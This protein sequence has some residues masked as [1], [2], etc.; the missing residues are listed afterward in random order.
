MA[1]EKPKSRL[2]I[3]LI[4]V[5]GL[6]LFFASG[7]HR[8]FSF[9]FIALHYGDL[10]AFIGDAPFLGYLVFSLLYLL[11]VAF[12]LPIASLLTLAGGALLGWPAFFCVV[13]AA[14]LGASLVFLAAKTILDGFLR[15]RAGAFL[16]KLERGFG[17]NSFGYLLVL[18]LMPIA[19]FWAVNIVPAFVGMRLGPYMLAT[20]IGIIPGSFVYIWVAQGFDVILAN[21]KTPDLSLL[22]SP[23]ILGPLFGLGMLALLPSL[24]RQFFQKKE[25]EEASK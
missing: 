13:L 14:T 20:A 24:Y 16:Q 19:P 25:K 2:F 1:S 4:L 9:E 18:R 7:L 10:K 22:A 12:S 6:L 17:Q 23:Q 5:A 15:A 3:P 8:T 11:T 21:G